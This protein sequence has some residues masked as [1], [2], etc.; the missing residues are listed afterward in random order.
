MLNHEL[1][2]AAHDVI[3][4][5]LK[6]DDALALLGWQ[7]IDEIERIGGHEALALV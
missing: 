4:G 5:E 7:I 3:H 6:L 1:A 2:A